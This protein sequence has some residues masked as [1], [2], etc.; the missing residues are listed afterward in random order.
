MTSRCLLAV[1][2]VLGF[3][4][5][6]AAQDSVVATTTRETPLAAD[7]GYL[8]YSVWD[9]SAYRLTLRAHGTTT[10]VPVAPGKDAFT[11]DLG[12][13]PDGH[14][15]AV[16]P[17]CGGAR[18]CD[19]YLYDLATQR[20]RK[21]TQADSPKDSELAGA[22]WH[23]TLVFARRYENK[24]VIYKRSL[25]GGGA[26]VRIARHDALSVDVRANRVPF[27]LSLEWSNEP[28]LGSLDGISHRIRQV[29]GSGAATSDLTDVNPTAYGSSVW[30][31]YTSAGDESWSELHRFDGRADRR[32]GARMP[33]TASGF[34]FDRGNAYFAMPA[35][36]SQ[37]CNPGSA[38]PTTIYKRLAPT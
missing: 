34:A 29:P 35:D 31:L 30:W 16:Y 37:Q 7:S 33:G 12:P 28:W 9:G 6:A 27:S 36:P 11:P 32:V 5:T 8:M 19:L 18:G 14:E 38:C 10:T 26:S 15:V 20:E 22:V 13:G 24:G 17:R 25:T 23:D 3:P 1:A 4:A 21:L 2:V